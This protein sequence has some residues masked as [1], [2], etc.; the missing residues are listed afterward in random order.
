MECWQFLN[1]LIVSLHSLTIF[2]NV[3]VV[4][5]ELVAMGAPT[6]ICFVNILVCI[7]CVPNIGL[8]D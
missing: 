7:W 8:T 4:W 5:N 6:N 3:I 1:I 2:G